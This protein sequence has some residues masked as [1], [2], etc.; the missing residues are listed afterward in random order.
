VDS[1]ILFHLAQVVAVDFDGTLCTNKWPE[2]GPAN[3]RLIEMLKR[4][5]R[6]RGVRLILWTCR[7]GEQLE[8]AIRWCA[9]HGL[10]FDAVNENLPERVAQYGGDCRKVS[11][12]L[13][14]DDRALPFLWGDG[15][16]AEA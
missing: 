8:A 15:I 4:R 5:K 12:D 13:Y 1:N 9:E 14:I 16:Y 3:R 2:I 6:E 7:T 10:T 11:A